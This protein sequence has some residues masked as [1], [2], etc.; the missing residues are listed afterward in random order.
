M[1]DNMPDNQILNQIKNDPELAQQVM[2]HLLTEG[3]LFYETLDAD[4]PLRQELLTEVLER[5]CLSQ[6]EFAEKTGAENARITRDVSNGILT[7]VH[8][9]GDKKYYYTRLFWKEDVKNYA[10]YVEVTSYKSARKVK[11]KLIEKA[12]EREVK[13]KTKE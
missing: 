11:E 2:N 10:K 7:P 12:E 1:P 5:Y 6:A 8:I 4:K 9:F 3:E 13:R